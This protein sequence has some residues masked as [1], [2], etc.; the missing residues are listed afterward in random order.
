MS[1]DEEFGS[2]KLD[3]LPTLRPAFKRDGSVTAANSST[4][5]DGASAVL[6]MSAERAK[7]LGVTPLARIRGFGD[8]AHEVR[9]NERGSFDSTDLPPCA[10]VKPGVQQQPCGAEESRAF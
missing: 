1:A 4:I 5:N 3:K 9:G 10:C 7:E 2:I 8:A 6:V